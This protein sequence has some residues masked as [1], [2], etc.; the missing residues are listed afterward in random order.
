MITWIIVGGLVL[1]VLTIYAAAKIGGEADDRAE[2][3]LA[4]EISKCEQ[5]RVDRT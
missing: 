1:I 4:N 5:E 3:I 2:R